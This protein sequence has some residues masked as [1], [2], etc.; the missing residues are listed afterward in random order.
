MSAQRC[1][2]QVLEVVPTVMQVIRQH[3]RRRRSAGLSVPQFRALWIINHNGSAC[4]SDVAEHIGSSLPSASRL[5]AALVDHGLVGRKTDVCDRRQ[6]RLGLTMDGGA[7]L[8]KAWAGTHDFMAH[9]VAA[10]SGPQR[11]AI[12]EAMGLLRNVF[13]KDV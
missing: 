4:V 2:R 10:L 13:G 1:A 3:T 7:V 5:V 9:K 12:V 11:R 8:K 6:C